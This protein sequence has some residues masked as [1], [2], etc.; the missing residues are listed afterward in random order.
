MEKWGLTG[1]KSFLE[2]IQ[3]RGRRARIWTLVLYPQSSAFKPPCFQPF[4]HGWSSAVRGT[5]CSL[6][7]LSFFSSTPG[8]DLIWYVGSRPS[9]N[10]R[11]CQSRRVNSQELWVVRSLWRACSGCDGERERQAFE[12]IEF[13]PWGTNLLWFKA[14]DKEICTPRFTCAS[15][16]PPRP[17]LAA[18]GCIISQVNLANDGR[19]SV[20]MSNW[21]IS[22]EPWLFY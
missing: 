11:R 6:S 10:A 12:V 8:E 7:F 13:Y 5:F 2:V 16:V 14:V 4:R 18:V 1:F 21:A 9:P 20:M 3:L 15:N 19:C 17:W 22:G